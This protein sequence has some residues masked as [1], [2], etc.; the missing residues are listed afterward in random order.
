M[1]EIED[2]PKQ[3]DGRPVA[4]EGLKK[5]LDAEFTLPLTGKQLKVCVKC[6]EYFIK[7]KQ[8]T[9]NPYTFELLE[10]LG[11]KPDED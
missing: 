11:M 3:P 6:V 7:Q 8:L 2:V 5:W 1:P 10:K 9:I 4:G